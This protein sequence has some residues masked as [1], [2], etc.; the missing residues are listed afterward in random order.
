VHA[1]DQIY[2]KVD[3]AGQHALADIVRRIF[4]CCDAV[5]AGDPQAV[6]AYVARSMGRLLRTITSETQALTRHVTPIQGID[7]GALPETTWLDE[8]VS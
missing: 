4:G 2:S 7:Q 3:D 6:T 8:M 5:A 1:D